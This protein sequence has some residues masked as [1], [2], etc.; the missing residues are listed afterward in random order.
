MRFWNESLWFTMR[1]TQSARG[2]LKA[3]ADCV[4]E[5]RK[6]LE[7]LGGGGICLTVKRFRISAALLL[8]AIWVPSTSHELLE[9]W[10]VIHTQASDSGDKHDDDHDAADGLCRLPPG[11]Y[12]VQKFFGPEAA[13]VSLALVQ[14]EV[15]SVWQ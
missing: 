4:E 3:N 6:C 13:V 12:Q 11:A 10:G 5:S 2:G 8:L 15:D 9:H 1:C 14:L 7:V